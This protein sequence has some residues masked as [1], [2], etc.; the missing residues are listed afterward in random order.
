MSFAVLVVILLVR[1]GRE[2]LRVGFV[3]VNYIG[4]ALLVIGWIIG[5]LLA[6]IDHLFYVLVCNP[7]ELSC[8]RV[9]N[10]IA[11]RR[12]GSAW[13]MLKSTSAERT[14]LPVHNILTLA[15]VAGMGIWMVTSSSSL[16]ASGIVMGLS[17]R[18]VTE[19]WQE[20][21]YDKWYW[22][23]ARQFNISEH[24]VI[25]WVLTGLIVLQ[26]FNIVR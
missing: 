8:M 18:L 21:N 16:L 13:R 15:L 23:F 17:V 19:L 20:T 1:V 2:W 12:F 14:R 6:E 10:E 26:G 4:N 5:Y 24:N 11:N 25:R 3:G 7:Q 22:L 9:R